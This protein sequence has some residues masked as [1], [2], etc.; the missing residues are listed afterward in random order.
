MEMLPYF[1]VFEVIL[2]VTMCGPDE[3]DD[4]TNPDE[5][6]YDDGVR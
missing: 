3:P 4:D 2:I 1:T 5:W 6:E